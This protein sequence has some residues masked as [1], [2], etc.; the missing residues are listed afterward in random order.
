MEIN[1]G[2]DYPEALTCEKSCK[3]WNVIYR[4]TI[5][6]FWTIKRLFLVLVRLA[7]FSQNT[8]PLMMIG[9]FVAVYF[10]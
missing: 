6:I 3:P 8:V 2:L 4:G 10:H 9:L 5:S 7:L 1:D